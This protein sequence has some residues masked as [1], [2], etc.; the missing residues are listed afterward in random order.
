MDIG[1]VG[2]PKKCQGIRS[3]LLGAV[4]FSS[5]HPEDLSGA[6][7]SIDVILCL[8]KTAGAKLFSEKDRE[9]GQPPVSRAVRR[10][11]LAMSASPPRN[12]LLENQ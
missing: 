1:V 3:N 11:P 4:L 5:R 9:Q 10:R 12:I 6:G 2:Q 8:R 7:W